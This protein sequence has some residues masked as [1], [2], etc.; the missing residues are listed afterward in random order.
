MFCSLQTYPFPTLFG[1]AP[2]ECFPQ[3]LSCLPVNEE[4]MGYF[5][6]F[7]G[8]MC[9]VPVDTTRRDIE[10]FIFDAR[11]NSQLHPATLAMLFGFIALGA[12]HSAWDR[13]G[14]R[15]NAKVIEAEAQKGN[16]YSMYMRGNHSLN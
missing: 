16:V 7:Q 15:W 5:G 2:D 9:Q 10:A 6:V 1:A 13:G 4:L 8:L 11:K 3:L 12:Q 14:R